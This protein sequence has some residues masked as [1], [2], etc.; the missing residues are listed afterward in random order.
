VAF[1][2]LR[3]LPPQSALFAKAYDMQ[4]TTPLTLNRDF[5]RL[6]KRGRSLVSGAVVVYYSKNRL[7]RNRIGITTSKKIGSAVRRNRARRI[8]REAYRLM[9]PQTAN[10]YDF[11]FVARGRTP[12]L[13]TGDVL[14]A[15]RRLLAGTGVLVK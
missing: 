13:G 11:V 6:Y 14:A 8:I 7:G 3:R 1:I 4:K 12:Y 9:E 5:L 15:L 2:L 10:G